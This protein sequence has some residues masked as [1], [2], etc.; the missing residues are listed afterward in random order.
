[1]S[2]ERRRPA[3]RLRAALRDT[4]RLLTFRSTREDLLALDHSHLAVGVLATWLAGVARYSHIPTY[5]W[6]K[7]IGVG[8]LV[9]LPALSLFLWLIYLPLRPEAWTFL[10]TLTFVSLTSPPA[11]LQAIPIELCLDYRENRVASAWILGVVTVWRTAL[12]LW[13]LVRSAGLK[14]HE[15]LVS[16][17]LP[18][19]LIVL[20]L[21]SFDVRH[22]ISDYVNAFRELD[23]LALMAF[24]YLP[25]PA[26][27][28]VAVVVYR[29]VARRRA[30]A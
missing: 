29:F 30:R 20:A 2:P 27:F 12:L 7:P 19:D 26:V 3:A 13:F 22:A 8:S 4:F 11:F 5:S 15:A 18:L 17:L 25:I 21:S 1:V 10:R 16:V 14:P 23:V 24:I 28:Y 6:E 9:Y